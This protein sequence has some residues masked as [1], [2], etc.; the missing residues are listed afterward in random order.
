MKQEHREF[1]T[2]FADAIVA[3]DFDSAHG[4]LA[5]WLQREMSPA[6]LQ[7]VVE[8]RLREMMEYAGTD[9][10]TYPVG[11]DVDGNSCTIADLREPRSWAPPRPIP[12]EVTPENFRQWACLQFLADEGL[13]IDAWFDLWMIVVETDEG[14]GVGYFELEDPD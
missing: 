13:D 8:A 10:L 5:P 12:P 9:E 1:A 2:R 4:L 3:K 14:Y 6:D 7:A 11:Y